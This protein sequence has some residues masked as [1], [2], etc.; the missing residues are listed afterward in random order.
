MRQLTTL[1]LNFKFNKRE[2]TLASVFLVF[3]VFFLYCQYVYIP[4]EKKIAAIKNDI[5]K[6]E[7]MINQ[8]IS[9]GYGNVS[10]L[11][12]KIQGMD[13]EIEKLYQKVPNTENKSGLLVDFYNLAI[14][15][16]VVA[17]TITFG[18]LAHN[19]SFSRF[20]VSLEVLGTKQDVFNFIKGIED[21]PRQSMISK[22]ELEPKEGNMISAKILD[23]FYVLQEVKNDPLEYPFMDK[24]Q[25]LNFLFDV[26]EQ[27]NVTGEVYQS[28]DPTVKKNLDELPA[29]IATPA[30]SNGVSELI[31][32]SG[33]QSGSSVNNDEKKSKRRGKAQTLIPGLSR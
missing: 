25:G 31:F 18:K 6:K 14:K 12:A 3:I 1:K 9:Q 20:Q 28:E 8:M 19:D 7:D 16:H 33:G 4:Q 11:D 27:Y 2:K 17:Q 10:D 21:Y 30:R 24:K 22:I 26:F 23:E 5:K 13:A 29:G 15:N 32:N